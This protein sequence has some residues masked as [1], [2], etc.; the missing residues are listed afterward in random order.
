MT[1]INIDDQLVTKRKFKIAGKEREMTYSDECA[2][3]IGRVQLTVTKLLEDIDKTDEKKLEANSVD[4]NLKFISEKYEEIRVAV[5][6]F[7]DEYFGEKTGQEIYEYNQEST[8]ALSI[9]FSKVAEYLEKT[10]IND[11]SKQYKTKH[12][13]KG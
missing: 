1:L 13:N 2:L 5:F 11:K 12:K 9:V 6:A 4:E 8:R 7:F 10:E 3:E